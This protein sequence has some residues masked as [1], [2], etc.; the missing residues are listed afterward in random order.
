[1][2]GNP[3]TAT[4]NHCG[5][6]GHWNRDCASAPAPKSAKKAR[7]KAAKAAKPAAADPAETDDKP[8]GQARFSAATSAASPHRV[9]VG[10]PAVQ[11]ASS[12]ATTINSA[13]SFIAGLLNNK[14][15]PQTIDLSASHVQPDSDADDSSDDEER[16]ESDD[17]SVDR[18]GREEADSDSSEPPNLADG[19]DTTS[20][21]DEG[22][23]G[24]P[25]AAVGH[26]RCV[27]SAAAASAPA[28][29]PPPNTCALPGC[30]RPAHVE[31]DGTV[32]ACC[33]RTHSTALSTIHAL[34]AQAMQTEINL[35]SSFAPSPSAGP[36]YPAM[37]MTPPTSGAAVAAAPM[38]YHEIRAAVA[39]LDPSM[40]LRDTIAPA[41][42]RTGLPVSPASG[43]KHKR[44]KIMIIDE[45]RAAVGLPELNP[46][47]G[48]EVDNTG[49]PPAP[50]ASP[51]APPPAA[52]APA[53]QQRCKPVR[54]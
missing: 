13:E 46:P 38:S 2:H 5:K 21:G 19:S 43:G 48:I 6:S 1:M 39:A 22:S 10:P 50:P 36:A 29:A 26:A 11:P 41:I 16:S 9:R 3:R 27:S 17:N 37:P 54:V 40:G 30:D 35:R 49:P 24:H 53:P 23:A 34:N 25:T 42:R 32:H 8:A 44:T 52:P 20:S 4:A 7:A 45:M 51:A 18:V 47:M 14:G 12:G 15:I 31:A 28:A 33:G